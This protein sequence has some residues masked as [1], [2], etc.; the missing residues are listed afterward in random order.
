MTV[1]TA[2]DEMLIFG[3]VCNWCVSDM[4]HNCKKNRQMAPSDPILHLST[5]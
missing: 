4:D 3:F 5:C 2:G 1:N